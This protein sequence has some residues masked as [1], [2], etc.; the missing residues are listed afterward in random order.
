M[1]QECYK[2]AMSQVEKKWGPDSDIAKK[3]RKRLILV[4]KTL[5]KMGINLDEEEQ[6]AQEDP[7]EVGRLSETGGD[8]PGQVQ[9]SLP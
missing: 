3:N 4:D 5:K 1:I 9:G 2:E 7:K 8:N 6:L